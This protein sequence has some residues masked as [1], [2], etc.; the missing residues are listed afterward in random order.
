MG[1]AS[2]KGLAV[3]AAC[4]GAGLPPK[5]FM[6]AGSSAPKGLAPCADTPKSASAAAS[7]SCSAKP[8]S[9]AVSLLSASES[10]PKSASAAACMVKGGEIGGF[11]GGSL[12]HPRQ[13]L[14]YPVGR[15]LLWE[16]RASQS[17]QACPKVAQEPSAHR[18]ADGAEEA[19]MRGPNSGTAKRAT[20]ALRLHLGT[21]RDG[22]RLLTEERVRRLPRLLLVRVKVRVRVRVRG[23]GSGLGL[24]LGLGLGLA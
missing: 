23:L 1:G 21:A 5:G 22:A 14:G 7:A 13:Q 16:R 6:A 10:S 11:G 3:A 9:L 17:C 24:E 18:R 4:S 12:E 20:L 8:T 19:S 15:P 2:P